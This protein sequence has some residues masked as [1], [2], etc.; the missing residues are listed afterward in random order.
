MI[1]ILDEL[2]NGWVLTLPGQKPEF[3]ETKRAALYMI[4][5]YIDKQQ[6]Y[7]LNLLIEGARNV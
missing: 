2:V 7:E 3:H 5:Q 1:I 6:R 4:S